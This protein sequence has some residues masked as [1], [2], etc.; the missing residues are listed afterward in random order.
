MIGGACCLVCTC[1]VALLVSLISQALFIA[2]KFVPPA[3]EETTALTASADLTKGFA[4]DK[5][6]RWQ[7]TSENDRIYFDIFSIRYSIFGDVQTIILCITKIDQLIKLMLINTYSNPGFA[8]ILQRF[9]K[10]NL[11]SCSVDKHKHGFDFNATAVRPSKRGICIPL[12]VPWKTSSTLTKQGRRLWTSLRT[13]L[14]LTRPL[15]PRATFS[16]VVEWQMARQR[17]TRLSARNVFRRH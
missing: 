1:L 11:Q 12:S 8:R 4:G 5:E 7:I 17:W 16:L 9:L 10:S 14:I 13:R 3:G 2:V 6:G 15:R